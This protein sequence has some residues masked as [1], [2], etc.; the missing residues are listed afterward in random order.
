MNAKLRLTRVMF[1]LCI[2][3]A[4]SSSFSA[5]GSSDAAEQHTRQVIYT[6]NA[7]T[8]V[9]AYS[10]AILFDSVLS[11]SGQIGLDP[12]TGNLVEGGVTAEADQALKNLGAVLAAAGMGYIDASMVTI[13]LTNIDDYSAVNTLYAT[14]FTVDPPARQVI[15][16]DSLPRGASVEISLVA[17]KSLN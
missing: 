15:A 8:P 14:Y 5:C 13:F 6:S 4:V 2:C 16:V 11:C 3:I 10:Q 1:V 17:M 7:P 9:G 12:V